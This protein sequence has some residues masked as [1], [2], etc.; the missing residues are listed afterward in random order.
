M[1]VL[2]SQ[3]N[4]YVVMVLTRTAYLTARQSKIETPYLQFQD[5][6]VGSLSQQTQ[7]ICILLIQRRPNVEDVGP[8]L[9]KC[10]TNVLCFLGIY[11]FRYNT[12][13]YLSII[14]NN[15]NPYPAK[16]ICL[17]FH[18]LEVVSRHRDPQLQV[19]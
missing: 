12:V 5:V 1:G 14:Y 9:S 10:Y 17:N 3:G 13:Y 11:H 7:H 19:G 16:V 6:T 4:S 8:T 18:P 15:I 2:K